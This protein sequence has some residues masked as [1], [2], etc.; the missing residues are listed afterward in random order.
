V[1]F[2][3]LCPGLRTEES[4]SLEKDSDTRFLF[5]ELL[6]QDRSCLEEIG[7]GKRGRQSGSCVSLFRRGR[8]GI[9]FCGLRIEVLK[10][11]MKLDIKKELNSHS[12]RVKSVDLHPTEPWVL[13]C[14]YDG[15]MNIY[16]YSTGTVVKSFEVSDQ[17]VRCGVFVPRKQWIVCGCD[18]M[19]IRVYNYN[20]MEKLQAFEAHMDYIRSISVHPTLPLVVTASDDMLIKLWD[21]EKGWATTMIYEGHGHYV[22]QVLFNP[23]DPNTFA[24]ASLD[25][26][27]KVWSISSPIPNMTLEGHERGVNCIDYYAGPDKPY[28]CSGGDDQVIK[29]WDYQTRSCVQTLEYHEH[30]VSC[31]SFIHDRPLILSGSEDGSAVLWNSNTY[32]NEATIQ[33]NKERCWSASHHKGLNRI[34]LGYDFGTV[35]IKFGRDSPL[36]SMDGSGKVISIKQNEASTMNLRSIDISSY[37]D[38]DR[39]P[40]VGKELGATENSPQSIS[41]SPNGRFVS[42][43]GDGEYIVYTALAW[44]NKSFGQ[45]DEVVWDSGGGEYATRRGASD[46]RVFSNKFKERTALQTDFMAEG[47]FGG[48]LLC[49]RSSDFVCFFD[50]ES[51]QLIRRIDVIPT[52]IYW[53]DSDLV[54]LATDQSL[55]IL[56]FNREAFET[57]LD[58]CGGVVGPD[59]VEEAFQLLHEFSEK[60]TSGHWIGDC[61]IYANSN[62]QLNYVVGS[63][64]S[65][66]ND[67]D[68]PTF[69]LGYLTKDSRILVADTSVNITS[70]AL[71]LAVIEY[72][73]AII[74]NDQEEAAQVLPKVPAGEHNKLAKFLEKQG[75]KEQALD[76]ATDPDYMCELALGLGKLDLAADLAEKD[77]SPLKWKSIGDVAMQEG[78]LDLAEKCMVEGE[79]LPGLVSLGMATANAEILE[80]VAGTSAD[81]KAINIAFLSSFMLGRVDECLKILISSKRI[82]EAALFARSY[83]PSEVA[84]IVEMWK[85]DLRKNGHVRMAD[86]LADPISHAH[87]FEGY[88]ASLQAEKD[89]AELMLKMKEV[90]SDYYPAYKQTLE[91]G[92]PHQDFAH[93]RKGEVQENGLGTEPALDPRLELEGE[94]DEDEDYN[95]AEAEGADSSPPGQGD[96]DEE[97]LDGEEQ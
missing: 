78:R 21:W 19:M 24:S 43:C 7:L 77:P 84:R 37:G 10:M 89:N 3:L 4:K 73:T 31:V 83:C 71:N 72:K 87:L 95:P 44:R 46:I 57:V 2:C 18:D 8:L 47:I 38:G 48:N 34:A 60:V 22:M 32:T 11:P 35:V 93:D 91:S 29:L 54:A 94:D 68:G 1:R 81:G 30:N 12:D 39:L 64:V 96:D 28:L 75:Y 51:M 25:H 79:D 42:V 50:W 74:R 33:L 27:I 45:A 70:Y 63:E 5:S 16:D 97:E 76:L 53:A 85:A 41:H 23:K 40:L 36:V 61:F 80:R 26:T 52:N 62:H 82:P 6:R 20:T 86:L 67:M 90:V 56:Q 69:I 49:I 59:G 13:S 58:Q 92:I 9:R 15:T 17:P 65:L 66:L 88:D 55:F 14:L